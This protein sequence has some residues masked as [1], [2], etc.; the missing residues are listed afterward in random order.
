MGRRT[1]EE[2][3]FDGQHELGRDSLRAPILP[4]ILLALVALA[5]SIAGITG[6]R[7]ILAE[8]EKR[9]AAELARTR[10]EERLVEVTARV[11]SV[12]RK[13][14]EER[15]LTKAANQTRDE[16]QAHNAELE[17]KV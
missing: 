1:S 14:D 7:R 4:W 15:G 9:T 17:Q 16:A 8:Q 2:S 10:T 5:S 12:E 11:A 3:P 13:L 6:W